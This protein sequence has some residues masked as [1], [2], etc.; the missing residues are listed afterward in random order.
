SACGGGGGGDTSAAPTNNN[1]PAITSSKSS[2]SSQAS[3]AVNAAF[4]SAPTT[5][6]NKPSMPTSLQATAIYSSQVSLAWAKPSSTNPITS[7]RLT[8]NGVV[9]GTTEGAVES[10]TDTG[11]N[12]ENQY[13]YRVQGGDAQGNWSSLSMGLSVRTA[14]PGNDP[15]VVPEPPASSSTSSS[16]STSSR[17]SSSNSSAPSTSIPGGSAP[18]TDAG[19][20]VTAPSRPGGLSAVSVKNTSIDLVWTAA[21]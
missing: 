16:R 19:P 17:S 6:S 4:S 3:S 2:V 1:P 11:L 21:T 5:P 9:I 8:R 7:Y 18:N 14:P 15:E 20:D 13:T 12:P 10:F